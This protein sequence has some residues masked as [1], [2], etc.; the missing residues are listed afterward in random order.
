MGQY[1]EVF[2]AEGIRYMK[3][4]ITSENGEVTTE[5]VKE[6]ELQEGDYA[7]PMKDWEG[8]YME[9]IAYTVVDLTKSLVK[10]DFDEFAHQM[11]NPTKKGNFIL[12]LRDMLWA[13]IAM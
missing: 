6:S 3:K 10:R 5:I 4:F 1:K 12:F 11:K 7:I 2:D 13:N 9:G 8:K